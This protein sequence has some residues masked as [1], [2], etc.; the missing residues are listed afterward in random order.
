MLEY[1][2]R[3]SKKQLRQGLLALIFILFVASFAVYVLS[4]NSRSWFSDNRTASAEGMNVAINT[5]VQ[6]LAEFQRWNGSAW[7]DTDKEHLF[8][9]LLPGEVA[10]IR[11]R[12]TNRDDAAHKVT[13][14]LT[15]G[16]EIGQEVT[17]DASTKQYYYYGSQ[18]RIVGAAHNS[19]G[20]AGERLHVSNYT[21]IYLMDNNDHVACFSTVQPT[22]GDIILDDVA[23]DL[24]KGGVMYYYLN[25]EFINTTQDQNVFQSFR[26]TCTRNFVLSLDESD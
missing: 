5:D 24:P 26:G 22:P 9:D 19:A 23:W 8:T 13:A 16:Q 14:S 7:V 10:E 12:L 6:I 21:P 20:G 18:L 2:K 3:S 4:G 25:V 11:V 15:L 1:L 17:I